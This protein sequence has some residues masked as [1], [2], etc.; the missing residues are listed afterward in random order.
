MLEEIDKH[1]EELLE[2]TNLPEDEFHEVMGFLSREIDTIPAS[3]FEDFLQKGEE[4]SPDPKDFEY[5]ALALKQD[6]PIFSGDKKLKQTIRKGNTTAPF[7]SRLSTQLFPRLQVKSFRWG[8]VTVR[9]YL[10]LAR[11]FGASR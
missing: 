7:S 10:K 8:I 3:Q 9:D 5:F 1:R 11:S 6:C 2:G 4:V